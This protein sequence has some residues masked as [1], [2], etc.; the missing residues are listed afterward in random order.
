MSKLGNEY[1]S[2]LFELAR[3]SGLEKETLESLILIRN[4]MS[5]FPKYELLLSS[6]EISTCEKENLL[7]KAFGNLGEPVLS[8]I[9]LLCK[10]KRIHLLSECVNEY[11]KLYN[12]TLFIS[13]ARIVS[14]IELSDSEK[15]AIIKKLEK[16]TKNT[17][18]PE[19]EIDKKI[20]GGLIIYID[21]K[22]FDGSIKQ[23]LQNIKDV[24][25]K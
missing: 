5:L 18:E 10:N 2:A 12:E 9:K 25:K 20:F 1:T 15:S 8:F 7:D 16:I 22:V 21:D 11:E 4:E 13:H 6:P 23:K 19:Y 17:I 3:E 14:A 24:I